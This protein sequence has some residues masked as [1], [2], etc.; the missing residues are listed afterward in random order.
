MKPVEVHLIDYTGKGDPNPDAAAELLLYTKSTRLEQSEDTMAKIKAMT[1]EEKM[2][3]LDYMAMT[4]P[5]SWEF[6]HYSF[7][8]RNVTRAFTHQLVRTRTGSYAQQAMRIADMSGFSYAIPPRLKGEGK[9][10]QR[11][12]YSRTMEG[13]RSGYA[14]LVH[15]G[16][17]IEDARGV[18]PTNIHTNIIAGFNL[19]ALS[20]LVMKRQGMRVQDEYRTV[21]E[22]MVEEVLAVH[23]WASKFMFPPEMKNIKEVEAFIEECLEL[24]NIDKPRSL[25][26][27][28]NLDKLR[29]GDS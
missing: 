6:V 11:S 26:L 28:K 27:H 19:R 4:V 10:E 18:L 14:D 1:H 8:I 23:P 15:A 16:E 5:S 21:L 13:I 24:G 3:E 22:G 7:Q 25:Q 2:K 12:I 9:E 29:K 20:D 17:E